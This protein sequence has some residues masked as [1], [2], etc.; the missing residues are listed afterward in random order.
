MDLI[1][2]MSPQQLLIYCRN[3]TVVPAM[4]ILFLATH[5]IFVIIGSIMSRKK[6]LF[7]YIWIFSFVLSLAVLVF[8]I[9]S[10]N[11]IQN[12]ADLFR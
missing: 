10:P 7:F 4:I 12:I 3:T 11:L 2:N 8:L 1:S 9:L 6:I 5:L